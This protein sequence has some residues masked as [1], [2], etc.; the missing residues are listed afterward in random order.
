MSLKKKIF[1]GIIAL[2]AFIV[3]WNICFP[4]IYTKII[5][6]KAEFTSSHTE[7][8]IIDG[9]VHTYSTLGLYDKENDIEFNTHFKFAWYFPIYLPDTPYYEFEMYLDEKNK[10]ETMLSDFEKITSRHTDDFVMLYDEAYD[11]YGCHILVKQLEA[12]DIAALTTELDKYVDKNSVTSINQNGYDISYSIFICMDDEIYKLLAAKDYIS[13]PL[14]L[15]YIPN[16]ENVKITESFNGF[17]SE[18]YQDLGDPNYDEY[19]DP[20]SFDHLV[21]LYDSSPYRIRNKKLLFSLYGIN[22]KE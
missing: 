11:Y 9:F 6:P 5:Y 17:S 19:Q 22:E 15:S 12:E 3:V 1:L 13:S 2:A 20:S 21:F 18:I 4:R 16:F 14:I 10:K 7:T 8:G